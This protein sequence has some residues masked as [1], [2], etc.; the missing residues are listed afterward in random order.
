MNIEDDKSKIIKDILLLPIVSSKSVKGITLAKRQ[1]DNSRFILSEQTYENGTDEDMSDIAIAFYKKIY[2]IKDILNENGKLINS[3]YAGDTMNS[4]N[5]ITRRASCSVEKKEE[6][7]RF[8]H[9]LANFWIL[10]MEIGRKHITG[11]SKSQVSKDYMDGFLIVLKD[12]YEFYKNKYAA[13]FEDMGDFQEFC[14]KQY[15]SPYFDNN[16]YEKTIKITGLKNADDSI[17]Q[18]INLIK[19]RADLL[20]KEFKEE[21]YNLFNDLGILLTNID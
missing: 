11:I 1:D 20:S 2:S 12:N 13:F 9:C 10:P 5:Q 4:F 14:K 16:D 17:E 15:I 6:W 3:E 19:L 21:L 7:F 18:M 8:Y